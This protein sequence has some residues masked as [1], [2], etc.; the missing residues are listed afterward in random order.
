MQFYTIV[1]KDYFNDSLMHFHK[2]ATNIIMRIRHKN[3]FHEFL[4]MLVSKYTIYQFCRRQF[5]VHVKSL[6]RE[7]TI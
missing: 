3:G 5:P 2:L 1:V 7:Y 6:K 4:L